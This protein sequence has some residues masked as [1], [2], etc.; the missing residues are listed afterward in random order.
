MTST[1]HAAPS[2]SPISPDE[3]NLSADIVFDNG[4]LSMQ[5]GKSKSP[6]TP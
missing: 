2:E 4:M 1:E 6:T 3:Q 5:L